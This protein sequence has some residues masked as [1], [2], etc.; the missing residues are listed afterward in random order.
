MPKRHLRD[1]LA[2]P[3]SEITGE[4]VYR[5]RRRLLAAIAV[6][7]ALS[8]AG[9]AG[10]ADE[11][12]APLRDATPPSLARSGFATDEALTS[13]RDVTSYNNF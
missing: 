6:A 2:I 12:P 1:A 13:E 10:A 5:D 4:A 8:L 11:P 3:G 9:C 7:P